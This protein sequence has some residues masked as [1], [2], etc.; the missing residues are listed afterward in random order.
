MDPD[1][2]PY[3]SREF[4]V[5]LEHQLSSRLVAGVR[6]AHKDL[7]K[8]IEDI[9]VLDAEENEVYLIGNPG[10]GWTRNDPL[11]IYDG[12]TPDGQEY[13]V[14]KAVRKY[15]AVEFRLQ[16]QYREAQFIGSYTWSRLYGNYAGA[17]N[18]DE[19]GRSDPGVSRAFDLPYYYFDASGS[20]RNVL[21]RLGTD[22]PHTLKLFGS[23]SLASKLGTTSFGLNQIAYSGTPDST[24]VIYLSAPTYPYGR[25]DMGRTPTVTQTDLMVKHQCCPN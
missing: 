20:Q 8:A 14:P 9:G 18:S 17:A 5:N 11:H 21:G 19:S 15:D 10:F 23:Y 13:L 25:G 3:T 6:Y 24:T 12:K 4:S 1:I 16:G 22:R 2:K 7:L